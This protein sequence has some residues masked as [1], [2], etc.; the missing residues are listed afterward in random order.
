MKTQSYNNFWQKI[1]Q[2]ARDKGFP[3]RVMFELTYRC[4][5]HCQHCYVP[6]DYRDKKGELE[7]REVFDILDQLKDI[8]CFYLGFTGGEPFVRG[9]IMDILWYAKRRGFEVIIYTNGSLIDERIA[10]ELADLRP[11]KVDRVNAFLS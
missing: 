7:T 5:F 3:L 8:G 2:S 6:Q 1:H 10:C 4:N 11:N 9:D